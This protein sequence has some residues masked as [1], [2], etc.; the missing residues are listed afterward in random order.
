MDEVK[1]VINIVMVMMII[2]VVFTFL[3]TAIAIIDQPPGYAIFMVLVDML[4]IGAI[5]SLG[6]LKV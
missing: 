4:L 3:L 2:A 1:E 5:V 6:S